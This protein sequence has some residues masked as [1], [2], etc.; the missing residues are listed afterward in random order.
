[1]LDAQGVKSYFISASMFLQLPVYCILFLL[2]IGRALLFFCQ[3]LL[4]EDTEQWH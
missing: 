4:E 1:M 3:W 2:S